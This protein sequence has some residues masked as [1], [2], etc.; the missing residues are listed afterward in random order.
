MCCAALV[1]GVCKNQH[2]G[3]HS[4]QQLCKAAGDLKL[5][6]TW[7]TN[8]FSQQSPDSGKVAI[9]PVDCNKETRV[10]TF[11]SKVV[12]VSMQELWQLSPQSLMQFTI[13]VFWTQQVN[14]Q[15]LGHALST[16]VVAAKHM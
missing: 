11:F 10:D 12:F 13:F 15:F 6:H 5:S 4:L 7:L 1:A 2:P 14:I 3:R 8:S 16:K 9:M